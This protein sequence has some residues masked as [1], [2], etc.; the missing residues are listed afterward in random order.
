MC[1]WSV[2]PED[3]H[4]EFCSF[5]GGCE[6]YPIKVDD[7]SP[8]MYIKLMSDIVGTDI[9]QRSRL[10]LLVW[11]RNMVAYRLRL[12]GYS[13]TK[14]G[15]IM[16]LNH[17]TVLNCERQVKRMLERPLMYDKECELWQKFEN[18]ISLKK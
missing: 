4:C 15:K 14:I 9:L 3:R 10:Q 5:R 7:D 16:G 18:A 12:D 2:N 1:I 6:S 13:L 11:A 8:Y 17:T